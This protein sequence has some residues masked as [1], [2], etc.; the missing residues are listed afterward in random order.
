M[1]RIVLVFRVALALVAASLAVVA[2]VG[3]GLLGTLR[4]L[5]QKAAP[6]LRNL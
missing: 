2:A 4:I 6:Y 1:K 3:L 5:G